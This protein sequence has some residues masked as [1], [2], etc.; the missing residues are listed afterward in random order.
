MAEIVDKNLTEEW[1]MNFFFKFLPG[2]WLA[3]WIARAQV[4]MQ[5]I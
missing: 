1:I 4:P 5:T 3:F 2:A